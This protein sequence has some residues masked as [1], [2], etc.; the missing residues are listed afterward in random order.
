MQKSLHINAEKCTGCLQCEMACSYENY[1][2]FATAYRSY[3]ASENPK[4]YIAARLAEGASLHSMTRHMLGLFAGRPG[5]V[6]S[7]GRRHA[8]RPHARGAHHRR[9]DPL[10]SGSLRRS[11]P[12]RC[13]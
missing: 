9:S 2:T 8:R 10:R 11:A 12:P 4:D 7:R 13:A 3:Y 6:R 5:R 1:G